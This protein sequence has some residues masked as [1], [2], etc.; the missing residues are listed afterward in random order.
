MTVYVQTAFLVALASGCRVSEV[1]GLSGLPADVAFEPDGSV[2]LPF[3]FWF[4]RQKSPV[5]GIKAL[6]SVLC[7]D[8][9]DLL[10][11]PVRALHA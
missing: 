1:H 7:P 5:I 6:S 11:S 9:D 10:L 4:F 2:S 3:A 8:D